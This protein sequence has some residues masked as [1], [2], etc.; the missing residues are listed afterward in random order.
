MEGFVYYFLPIFLLASYFYFLQ[1]FFK[2]LK[3]YDNA[4]WEFLG[5]PS[6]FNLGILNG[7]QV[8]KTLTFSTFRKSG[9][10]E[11]NIW[12]HV[13]QLALIITFAASITLAAKAPAGI[14]S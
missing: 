8:L 14:Y 13:S 10:Q 7:M 5:K 9:V 12:G 4:R 11:I 6:I 1:M 2:A 3:N